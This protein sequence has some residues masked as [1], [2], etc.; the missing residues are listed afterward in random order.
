MWTIASIPFWCL[1][2]LAAMSAIGDI[3]TMLKADESP[4]DAMANKIGFEILLCGIY[5]FLQREFPHSFTHGVLGVGFQHVP[6]SKLYRV[7]VEF[8]G[9]DVHLRFDGEVCLRC[10]EAS[11][12]STLNLVCIDSEN[13]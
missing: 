10:A 8:V 1:A 13:I 11:E 2:A 7:D 4:T 5:A 9:N 6:E 12:G 3:V